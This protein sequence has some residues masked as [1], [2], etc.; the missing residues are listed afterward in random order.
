MGDLGPFNE[1]RSINSFLNISPKKECFDETFRKK[2]KDESA[3]E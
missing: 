3:F 1:V 2:M